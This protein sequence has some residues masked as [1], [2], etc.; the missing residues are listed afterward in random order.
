MKENLVVEYYEKY[1]MSPVSK[2][3]SDFEFHC[4]KRAKLYRQCGVNVVY[5][6]WLFM[7]QRFV[8]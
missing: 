7:R 6:A 4:R 2:D 3:L 8:K 1:H 5:P